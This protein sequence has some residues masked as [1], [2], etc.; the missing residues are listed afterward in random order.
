MWSYKAH[1]PY[2]NILLLLAVILLVLYA[3][4]PNLNSS[5]SILREPSYFPLVFWKDPYKLWPSYAQMYVW[6]DDSNLFPT[7]GN[8]VMNSVNPS[9]LDP[10]RLLYH[11]QLLN[12][13]TS[14]IFSS[15]VSYCYKINSGWRGF[16]LLGYISKAIIHLTARTTPLTIPTITVT[17]VSL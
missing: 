16:R 1:P 6:G 10:R 4:P 17:K 14:I 5:F 7:P 13:S 11:C 9:C 15:T 3:P 12:S 8:I 2:A